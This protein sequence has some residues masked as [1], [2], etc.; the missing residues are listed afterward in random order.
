M[1]PVQKG[2]KYGV[3]PNGYKALRKV[4]C[5][6]WGQGKLELRAGDSMYLEQGVGPK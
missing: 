2:N 1:A 4:D 3:L 5:G 6:V